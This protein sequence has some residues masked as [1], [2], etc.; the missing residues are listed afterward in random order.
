MPPPRGGRRTYDD[1]ARK[2]A[3]V[4][5]STT[6]TIT[7]TGIAG[8]TVTSPPPERPNPMTGPGQMIRGGTSGVE[9]AVA[10]PT[11][12]GY[13]LTADADL[14][15]VWAAPTGGGGSSGGGARYLYWMDPADTQPTWLAY[16][17][18]V[19]EYE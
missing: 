1:L 12:A 8:G 3:E 14:L 17:G 19:L 11:V 10:A 5:K 13:V 18:T 9:V 4:A 6:S 16:E 7:G 2:I 15:P